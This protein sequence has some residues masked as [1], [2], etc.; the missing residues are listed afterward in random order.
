MEIVLALALGAAFGFVLDRIGATDPSVIGGMLS[1]R[2]LHL[3]KTILFAIGVASLLM[4]GGQMQGLVDVG[5]MSIKAASFGVFLGGLILG[6]GWALSG[7]C[8]G[9]GVCA[10]AT[11]RVD[12]MV[13][14]IGGLLGAWAYMESFAWIEANGLLAP[15]L[16][17][18]STLG[19]VPGSD[20][21][22]LIPSA[23]GDLLGIV[24]GVVL[25]LIALILPTRPFR[26]E[27]DVG[28]V[29]TA[30][31]QPAE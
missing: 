24:L 29:S 12:A 16:G 15:I 4:F 2:L 5:H 1:L 31:A 19:A 21:P 30:A 18:K 14:V 25:M 13:Y 10:A 23:Q 11:G 17:G 22:A 20:A 27:P 8:P 9:T 6:V 3:M 28:P 26:R 7:Y